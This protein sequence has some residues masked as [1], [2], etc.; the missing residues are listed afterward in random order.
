MPT[1]RGVSPVVDGQLQ[2]HPERLGQAQLGH[3]RL[4]RTGGD[5]ATLTEQQRVSETGR[6]LL[7]MVRHQDRCRGVRIHRQR[8]QRRDEVLS[9]AEIQ[10]GGRLVE[11]QQ[12]GVGHQCPG[13]L[14][15]LAFALAQSAER[16]ISQVFGAY[17]DQEALGPLVVGVVVLLTPAANHAVRRRDDHVLNTF[18][19][20]DPLGERGTRQPDP[21]AQFEHI[22]S[23]QHLLEDAGDT[24]GRMDQGASDLKQRGL[25]RAVGSKDHPTVT[26]FDA[27]VDRI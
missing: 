16:P 10:S 6:D 5:H 1:P 17:L 27:P 7:H 26:G 11:Q 25:A 3:G 13:D 20:G 18:A 8:R 2:G 14:D 21:W 24:A 22:D 4:D 15:P 23:A 19:A 9:A 12:L